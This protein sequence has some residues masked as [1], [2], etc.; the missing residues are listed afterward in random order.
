ML[1]P[2]LCPSGLSVRPSVRVPAHE[3]DGTEHLAM[4]FRA[5]GSG[6]LGTPVFVATESHPQ[7]RRGENKGGRREGSREGCG[8][9][10]EEVVE[11]GIEWRRR[12]EGAR[13]RD[14]FT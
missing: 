1:L 2:P 9:E 3:R 12:L 14:L 7:G 5:T 6:K 8:M 4:S 13:V 11:K 10:V